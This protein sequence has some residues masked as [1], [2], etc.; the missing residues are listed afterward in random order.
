MS[1][2]PVPP[3]S[4]TI[5]LLY[6]TILAPSSRVS[7]RIS[8]TMAPSWRSSS[9]FSFRQRILSNNTIWNWVS[10]CPNVYQFN[11]TCSSIFSP[12]CLPFSSGK[13]FVRYINMLINDTTFLLDESL[14]SL[15][16]IHEVQ[17][18]MKNK[19]QWEQLPRV[20]SV[21]SR[22][23]FVNCHEFYKTMHLFGYYNTKMIVYDV[24]LSGRTV[25]TVLHDVCFPFRSS[26]R[27]ASPSWLRMSGF[28][29]PIWRS[30]RRRLTCFTFLPNR[31]RSLSSVL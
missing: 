9:E 1:S 12:S 23:S 8:H 21:F 18:E 20:C 17:E 11:W 13:Q 28:L 22:G 25:L 14:E 16:R 27:A 26:S 15:K 24:H 7:G 30:Q 19:E 3:A 2:I 5:S 31:S 10:G 4:S 29:A 6:G